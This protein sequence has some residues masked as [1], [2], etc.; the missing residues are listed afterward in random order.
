MLVAE[1]TERL[2]RC[3]LRRQLDKA[4]P[5]PLVDRPTLNDRFVRH[6][7]ALADRPTA[8]LSTVELLSPVPPE[9]LAAVLVAPARL[10]VSGVGIGPLTLAGVHGDVATEHLVV[11][12]RD[13]LEERAARTLGIDFGAR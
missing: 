1:V 10:R 3:A 2:E 11:G 5:C 13:G 7:D 12:E 4:V 6:P 8:G 9:R